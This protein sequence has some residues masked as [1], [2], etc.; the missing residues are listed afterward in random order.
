MY[1][2]FFLYYSLEFKLHDSKFLSTWFG[3]YHPNI[4]NSTHMVGVQE[5]FAKQMNTY[6]DA[7]AW[8]FKPL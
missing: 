7:Q 4:Y 5:I 6:M 1:L 3:Y 8:F 2:L